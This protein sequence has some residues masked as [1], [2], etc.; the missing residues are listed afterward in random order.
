V[1]CVDAGAA[2]FDV[3]ARPF[4]LTTDTAFGA[5]FEWERE[6]V[7]QWELSHAPRCGLL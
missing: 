1:E 4:R 2:G 5:E 6:L 3:L 7:G